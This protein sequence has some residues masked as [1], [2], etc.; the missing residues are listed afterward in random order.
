MIKLPTNDHQ[1]AEFGRTAQGLADATRI[2]K[3]WDAAYLIRAAV[4]LALHVAEQA[5]ASRRHV[6]AALLAEEC[7]GDVDTAVDSIHEVADKPA[8]H[9][10][11]IAHG[12][13]VMS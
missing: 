5:G 6:L 7:G 9:L 2:L 4:L 10:G 12:A 8:E 11:V 3:V 1:R 13:K